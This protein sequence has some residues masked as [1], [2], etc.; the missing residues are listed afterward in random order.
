MESTANPKPSLTPSTPGSERLRLVVRTDRR[1]V[2][3]RDAQT[4]AD[5]RQRRRQRTVRAW[6][7]VCLIG[8]H[9]NVGAGCHGSMRAIVGKPYDPLRRAW[10]FCTTGMPRPFELAGLEL[11]LSLHPCFPQS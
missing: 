3:G 11:P 7:R 8:M 10:G 5:V 1:T 4:Q 9:A 6:G 2:A